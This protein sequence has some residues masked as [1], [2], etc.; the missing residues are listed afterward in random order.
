MDI[1]Q[2]S[3]SASVLIAVVVIIRALA[4]HKLPKKTF[5]VLWGVVICRLFLPFSIPFQFSFYTGMDTVKRI[6]AETTD[7][8]YPA[9]ITDILHIANLSGTGE[10]VGIDA[11]TVSISP[12]VMIWLTGMCACAL[13]FI[14]VYIKCRREFGMSL[15]VENDFVALWLR[16]HPLRRPVQIRQ[17]DRVKSPLTYGVFRPVVL[18]PKTTDWT[19]ET[20]LRYILTHEF[21][22]IRRFDALTKLVLAAA[23]CVH[24]FN[25]FVWVMYV[26]ANRDIELSCDEKVVRTFGET[27]KSAYAMTLIELE[28]K[29]SHHTPLVNNFSKNAIE[30]RVVSIMKMKKVS[31]VG[32]ILAVALVIGT[33]TVFAT[34]DASALDGE[35]VVKPEATAARAKEIVSIE[36]STLPENPAYVRNYTT[37][38]KI[39]SVRA[40]LDS[41]SWKDLSSDDNPDT[42]AGMT[43]M[44]TKTFSDGTTKSYYFLGNQY[45][46]F[47]GIDW[48]VLNYIQGIEL[49]NIIND[50]PTDV[51]SN[52]TQIDDIKR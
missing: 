38:D 47:D 5:L 42:H 7:V 36:V 11:S 48:K 32:M 37:S 28:E 6:F 9:G 1:F 24:W 51:P 30:E 10:S 27:K 13:F 26:L 41:L 44:V 25:P 40:Y 3:L 20:K 12:I 8:S 17:S 49:E 16:E 50:R 35:V 39:E 29:K 14:V 45:F 21:V 22:H 43:F 33:V 2:M 52:N 34:N 23:V 4:L 31:L 19:E 15:P 18:L 46:K